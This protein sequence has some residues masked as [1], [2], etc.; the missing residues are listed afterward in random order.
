MPHRASVCFEGSI[1][2]PYER[3]FPFTSQR[4]QKQK[5][6]IA[7]RTP[8]FELS[9]PP[10]LSLFLILH[11]RTS[12]GTLLC[13]TNG[14]AVTSFCGTRKEVSG[15]RASW[16]WRLP[17]VARWLLPE[18]N[19]N[20]ILAPY[21]SLVKIRCGEHKTSYT[22]RGVSCK[23]LNARCVTPSVV[24]WRILTNQGITD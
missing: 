9:S 24:M 7:V 23:G 21:D 8:F 2:V 5:Q 4:F 20:C 16:V 22:D 1:S 18:P 13:F 14:S 3:W 12:P 19:W 15:R 6:G 17:S 10:P 11:I